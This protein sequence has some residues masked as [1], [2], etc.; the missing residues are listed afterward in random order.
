[1]KS[2]TDEYRKT[3]TLKNIILVIGIFLA[4]NVMYFFLNAPTT[5]ADWRQEAQSTKSFDEEYLKDTKEFDTYDNIDLVLIENAKNEI[6]I[7]EYSLENNIPYGNISVWTHSQNVLIASVF[8][9]IIMVII[10]GKTISCEFE[11]GTWKNLVS[12]GTSRY[13]KLIEKYIY[14]LLQAL[15]GVFLFALVTF[16]FGSIFYGSINTTT[17]LQ[18]ISNEI[19]KV[20]LLPVLIGS[21]YVLFMKI[22]FFTFFTQSLNLISRNGKF[23]I[24]IGVLFIVFSS[25]INTYLK[26]YAISKYLPFQYLV[27]KASDLSSVPGYLTYSFVLIIYM[28]IFLSI[29]SIIFNK[30]DIV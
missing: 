20:S 27:Y 13:E 4:I 7:I 5:S 15:C 8:V 22:V 11:C 18:I 28:I 17:K 1:M 19:V 29:G 24:I 26:D 30:R 6:Q 3:W 14:T 9:V 23:S 16:I 10:G 2:L 25:N 21:F 12:T